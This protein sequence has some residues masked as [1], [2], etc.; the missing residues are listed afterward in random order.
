MQ[1][2]D[3]VPDPGLLLRP[4]I[5]AVLATT[6]EA[7]DERIDAVLVT[8]G[9]AKPSGSP[10]LA[11]HSNMPMRLLERIRERIWALPK[12]R[13][14]EKS[15]AL[16]CVVTDVLWGRT[17]T[18]PRRDDRSAGQA[19]TAEA[20]GARMLS[21]LHSYNMKR[22]RSRRSDELKRLLD[23]E[24]YRCSFGSTPPNP[25]TAEEVHSIDSDETGGAD[26]SDNSDAASVS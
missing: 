20:V 10:A 12:D 4:S 25:P 3:S 26:G 21:Y 15:G 18:L 1:T 11:P 23:R 22:E 17:R 8:G 14:C 16:A 5:T 2:D 19:S 13:R 7:I 24:P 6:D 9:G